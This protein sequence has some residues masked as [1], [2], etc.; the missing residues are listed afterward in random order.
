MLQLP[1]QLSL[2]PLGHRKV[3]R[4]RRDGIPNV[5]DE[6]QPLLYREPQNLVPERLGGHVHN[7][8]ALARRRLVELW[9]YLETGA[10]PEGAVVKA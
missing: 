10:V 5:L 7:L 1:I 6:L 2:V 9:R 4:R 8:V 3:S